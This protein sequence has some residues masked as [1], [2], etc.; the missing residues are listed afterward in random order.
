MLLTSHILTLKEI[1]IKHG[2]NN[3]QNRHASQGKREF[4]VRDAW[5]EW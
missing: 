3:I 5:P 4:D 1:S 2:K